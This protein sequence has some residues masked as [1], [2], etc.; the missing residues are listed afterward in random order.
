MIIRNINLETV[1]VYKRQ[2]G[3][4]LFILFG[5]GAEVHNHIYFLIREI[6]GIAGL[7]ICCKGIRNYILGNAGG[8]AMLVFQASKDEVVETD[9]IESGQVKQ[10]IQIRSTLACLIVRISLSGNVQHAA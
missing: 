4:N 3:N 1:D 8:R 6:D 7:F 10:G 2:A 9:L 5:K